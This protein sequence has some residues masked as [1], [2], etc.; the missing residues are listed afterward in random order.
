MGMRIGDIAGLQE[1]DAL[2][3]DD[4]DEDLTGKKKTGADSIR[5]NLA[6]NGATPD[7]IEFLLHKRVELNAFTSDALV[8]WIEAKLDAYGVTRRSRMIML[9]S[10]TLNRRTPA[11]RWIGV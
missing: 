10:R 1:E 6:R 7:E 2:L 9:S 4:D 5:E 8:A 11:A 3:I